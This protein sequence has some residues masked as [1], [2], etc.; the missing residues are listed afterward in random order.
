MFEHKLG[1]T[2]VAA[3]KPNPANA[4]THSQR[5]IK[6]VAASIERFGFINPVLVDDELMI[7]AGHA[8]VEAAKLLAMEDVPTLTLSHLNA[9]EQRAYQVA[10]NRL[11]ELARWDHKKLAIEL[12]GLTDLQFELGAIGFVTAEIDHI[13]ET[14]A[15]AD[16]DGRD[17]PEDAVH[18]APDA[19]V[20]RLGDLWRLGPHRLIC[21]DA[22]DLEAYAAL[23]GD[24]RADVVFTD[25]PYNVP[26]DGF[27]GG[28]GKVKH[29]DFAM[30]CGEMSE[31][32]FEAF[33]A[34]TLGPAAEHLKDGAIAFVCMDWRHMRELLNVGA[35]VFDALKNLCVWTKSNGGM[36]SLYRSQH[37]LVFV[38]KRGESPHQN[39]VELGRHGRNRTNVWAYAGA[40]TFK[41]GR[42]AELAMHPT[43]KPVALVQDALK[44]VTARN[45]I[46]LDPFGGSGSTLIAA[47]KSGRR[48]RLI[49]ID[50][51]YCDVIITRYEAYSG[52]RATLAATD[53][54]FDEI[55]AERRAPA[56]TAE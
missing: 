12:K 54:S 34:A 14:A 30:G 24:E 37:E 28:K 11:A 55:A 42:D 47:D 27:V 49:E 5:Q 15:D 17:A 46:V 50:P 10:D 20:T 18:S 23:L 13:L 16:P 36:G 40:N 26:I 41:Q 52:K 43:V 7:I 39:N 25:P 6:Q 1:R 31:A 9:D 19:P 2:A 48:A 33:L 3:L 35:K 29:E 4:R 56:T 44:D 21:A 51:A 38:F 45:A 32:E 22:R 53:A 8:R